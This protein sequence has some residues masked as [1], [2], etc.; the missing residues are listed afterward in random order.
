MRKLQDILISF[1]YD[2]VPLYLL[3]VIMTIASSLSILTLD[4]RNGHLPEYARN[5]SCLTICP[6]RH[7]PSWLSG[8]DA[9]TGKAGLGILLETHVFSTSLLLSSLR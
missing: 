4:E 3:K 9:C 8:A 6:A 2:A 5:R 7:Y 1:A